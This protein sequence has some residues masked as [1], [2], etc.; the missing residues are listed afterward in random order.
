[1][2]KASNFMITI[3]TSREMHKASLEKISDQ[4]FI[5]YLSIY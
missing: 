3:V 5:L 4:V 2:M 1:M